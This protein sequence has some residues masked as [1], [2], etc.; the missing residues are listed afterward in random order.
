MTIRLKRETAG[1]C[2]GCNTIWQWPGSILLRDATCPVCGAKLVRTATALVKD[3]RII[4]AAYCTDR[5]LRASGASRRS[6][7]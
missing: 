6:R 1:R 5:G 3:K 2:V 7:R 4:K